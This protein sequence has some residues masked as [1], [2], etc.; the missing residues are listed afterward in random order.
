MN[1]INKPVSFDDEPLILVDA[2]GNPAG[3]LPKRECHLGR[4]TLHR[5]FSVF[6]FN[7]ENQVLLQQRSADKMLWPSY[8]SNSCCSHP[9]LGEHETA[10]VHRRVS[11]E[12]GITINGLTKHYEFE[13][14]A[15]YRDIGSE[16]ELCSVLT[17]HCD[18]TLRIN[19]SE[20]SATRW[21]A[22][23]QLSRL[24]E[25]EADRFT[26]WIKLE[27]NRLLPLLRDD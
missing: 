6:V 12:L 10:A 25:T 4:G 2:E 22:T 9:R 17:A 14:Q 8:W 11:E 5:A 1:S 23:D 19:R 7:S 13:Y 18:Q 15:S 3:S 16:W 27:W 24:L 26:P 20:I 21:V